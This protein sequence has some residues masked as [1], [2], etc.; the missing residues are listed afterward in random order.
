MATGTPPRGRAEE[1]GYRADSCMFRV[2]AR[3]GCPPRNDFENAYSTSDGRPIRQRAVNHYGNGSSGRRLSCP[4]A[5]TAFTTHQPHD[6]LPSVCC[7]KMSFFPSPLKSPFVHAPTVPGPSSPPA[8]TKLSP[9]ISHNAALPSVCCHTMSLL[10]SPLKSQSMD[11]PTGSRPKPIAGVDGSQTHSSANCN[12]PIRCVARRCRSFRRV[13]IS[14]RW[15]LQPFPPQ[16]DRRRPWYSTII[17][18]S[19]A[20]PP[21]AARRCRS[22]RRR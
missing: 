10:P 2:S 19:A 20:L 5:P 16:A 4:A 22:I 21:C 6:G 7:Q 12:A 17:S 18:H 14:I 8:L 1:Q 3:E 13:K 9:F 11:S 15:T